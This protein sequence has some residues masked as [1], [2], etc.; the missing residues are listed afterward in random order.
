MMLRGFSQIYL[1]SDYNGQ[2]VN[3]CT[4]HLYDNGGPGAGYGNNLNLIM[5]ICSA[6]ASGSH[7][8]LYFTSF[9]I[10]PGDTL[11]IYDGLAASSPLIGTYNNDNSLFLHQVSSSDSNFSGCLTLRFISD[12]SVTGTGWEAE[13]SC[14][15]PCQSIIAGYDPLL[16]DPPPSGNG[17]I[18]ICQ[19]DT[20]SLT[21]TALFPE[22]NLLYTQSLATSQ[23][24]WNF[25]DG[26]SDTGITVHHVFENGGLFYVQLM[27][28]D[29]NHCQSLNSIQ[30]SIMRSAPPEILIGP[31]PTIPA[32]SG[33]TLSAGIDT[34]NTVQ[35]IP[36]EHEI[37]SIFI[38]DSAMLIPDGGALGG[39]CYLSNLMVDRY[40]PGQVVQNASDIQAVTVN[41]EH[42]FVGDLEISLLCPNGQ[43][44]ILKEYVQ[45][46]G[47]YLGIPMGGD[48]HSSYDCTNPP[49]CLSDPTQNPPGTGWTYTFT[50]IN[51]E[52]NTMQTYA[53]TGN[54]QP[55]PPGINSEVIDSGSYMPYQSFNNLIGCPLNGAWTFKVCDYWGVDNG[56]VFF[57]RLN[58]DPVLLPPDSAFTL[59]I[60]SISWNGPFITQNFGDSVLIFPT[61]VGEYLY[62]V[63][64]TDV[65]GCTYDTVITVYVDG[66]IGIP[67]ENDPNQSLLGVNLYPNPARDEFN[68]A[69]NVSQ[70]CDI[71][72]SII[73]SLGQTLMEKNELGVTAGKKVSVFNVDRL[74]PGLYHVLIQIDD[75]ETVRY[76]H[77]KFVITSK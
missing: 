24:Q 6:S 53:I 54:T 72:L 27:I 57:W 12:N 1:I 2:A 17:K 29:T 71:R 4:G 7:V 76:V 46:G 69:Y 52:Y 30:L 58:F 8:K 51:P 42:S 37:S 34:V 41:M 47:A 66:N 45:S 49:S 77:R 38:Q 48:S 40:L 28:T 23:F 15:T 11:F 64:F 56:W 35:V 73:N 25:G 39:N 31:S 5:T 36:F 33:L 32:W 55:P 74:S 13:I 3:T 22:N 19:G 59:P 67:I 61:E 26:H 75:P 60:D 18:V 9:D 65:L 20:V 14:F 50:P 68:I 10:D 21:G 16:C 62:I 63:S 43:E 70:H 44:A